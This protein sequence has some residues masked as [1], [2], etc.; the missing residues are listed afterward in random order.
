MTRADIQTSR[1]PTSASVGE[2]RRVAPAAGRA[3]QTVGSAFGKAPFAQ[4][5]ILLRNRQT[6]FGDTSR[7]RGSAL[8]AIRWPEEGFEEYDEINVLQ[9]LFPSVFAY[10]FADKALLQARME[11]VTTD[12]A[13][14]SGARVVDGVIVG[15]IDDGEPLFTGN[16]DD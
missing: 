5:R 9:D 6:R 2:T 4:I 7:L 11:P 13:P 15:G 8:L 3:S 14:A 1:I 12:G 10:M 16:V